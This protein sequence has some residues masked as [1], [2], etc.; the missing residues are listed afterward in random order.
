ML[1][2]LVALA[3]IGAGLIGVAVRWPLEALGVGGALLIVSSVVGVMAWIGEKVGG[4][5][6]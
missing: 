3:V 2:V 5:S 6:E 1:G 4:S